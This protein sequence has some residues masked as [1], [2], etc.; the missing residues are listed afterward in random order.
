MCVGDEALV[1]KDGDEISKCKGG[2]RGDYSA[3]DTAC[4]DFL[5]RDPRVTVRGRA[6][7]SESNSIGGLGDLS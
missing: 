6:A 1:E 4:Q 2:P 7:P 5:R 3:E